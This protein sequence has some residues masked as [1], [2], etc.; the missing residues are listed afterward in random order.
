MFH[1]AIRKKAVTS[2]LITDF[3]GTGKSIAKLS[4]IVAL[5]TSLWTSEKAKWPRPLTAYRRLGVF[6]NLQAYTQVNVVA[7]MQ[8]SKWFVTAT[9]F[10]VWVSALPISRFIF[11]I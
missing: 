2:E 11:Y 5:A 8:N 10:L 1:A 4:S 6:S 7:I 9:E 3:L